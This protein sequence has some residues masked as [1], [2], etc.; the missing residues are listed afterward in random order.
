[1]KT[2]KNIIMGTAAAMAL[3]VLGITSVSAQGHMPQAADKMEITVPSRA[4]TVRAGSESDK[5]EV[6][7][8]GSEAVTDN[9]AVTFQ[10]APGVMDIMENTGNVLIKSNETEDKLL[11]SRDGGKT[12]DE[13][14]TPEAAR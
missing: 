6:V 5:Y 4:V 8:M 12:W 9:E 11:I 13:M 10:D 14:E 2:A 3:S 1:M 7:G